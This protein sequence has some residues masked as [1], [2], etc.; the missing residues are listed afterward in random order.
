MYYDR[1]EP[2]KNTEEVPSIG[3][4]QPMQP[5]N[6]QPFGQSADQQPHD[7]QLAD[8]GRQPKITRDL[9]KEQAQARGEGYSPAPGADMGRDQRGVSEQV[10]FPSAP[11]AYQPEAG[12]SWQAGATNQPGQPVAGPAPGSAWGYPPRPEYYQQR[13]QQ[14]GAPAPITQ[15]HPSIMPGQPAHMHRQNGAPAFYSSATIPV[16]HPGGGVS[17]T[18]PRRSGLRTGTLI[19]LALLL[20]LVF[21]TGIF[22]GWQFGRSGAATSSVDNNA[23]QPGARSTV[24]VP[25]PNGSNA[26]QVREA[27]INKVQPGVVQ[28]VVNT[29]SQQALGSGVIIDGRGYIVTNNHVVSGANSIQVTLANNQTLPGKVVGTDTVDDLA[30][31]FITPPAGGLTTVTMGDSAQLK[32]GQEV[33][34]IG[35]PL[36]NA[37]TVTRGIISALNRNVSEGESGP[38]LP[39]AI[40]TDA[41]INP[42]NSGGALVDLQG[43]LIGMPTLNA[44]D[45]EFN[46]PANGLGFAIPVNRIRFIAQQ[47]ITDGHV[48]HTGRPILGVTVTTVT[49]A[50]AEQRHLSATSGVLI[51]D[52]TAGGPAASAGL[53]AN[54]VITQVGNRTV[55]S[56]SD[57]SAALLQQKPGDSVALKINRGGQQLTLNVTLGELPAS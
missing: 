12:R 27:V 34:A 23:F 16:V 9:Q 37:E 2:L 53:K 20:I 33:L 32:A 41:P 49:S 52:T 29:G 11:S 26:D 46:T 50:L 51:V 40:Q 1:S 55:N 5:A 19:A 13:A 44:V 15:P 22:A 39:D 56:T 6:E 4:G 36:G 47:I 35:S 10:I 8:Q 57:L 21:G 43:N 45:T 30:V 48:S 31:I 38:I 14:P 54:D 25:Q 42:G 24:A 18:P 3:E 17:S 7:D 28:I